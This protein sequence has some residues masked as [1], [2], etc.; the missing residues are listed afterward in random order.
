MFIR[1]MPLWV[2]GTNCWIVSE[3]KDSTECVLIDVPPDIA[4]VLSALKDAGLRPVAILATH[5]H[6]DHVGGISALVRSTGGTGSSKAA[7]VHIHRE[8]RHMLLDPLG[9]S[10]LLAAELIKTGLDFS[11]PELILDVDDGETITGPGLNFRAIHTPGHTQGSTCYLLRS[12]SSAEKVLF[13]G[14]HLFQGSIGRTDL[15]GGS[16]DQL[17]VSMKEKILTLDDE[18]PVLP[19]HGSTTTIG[20][21]RATNPFLADI[22]P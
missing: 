2:A 22:Q 10:G 16:L 6:A 18:I 15:P 9:T 21:E 8:D 19:G 4:R 20:I 1:Q 14:D 17:L 11:A 13:S 5:G 7:A 12:A 3:A